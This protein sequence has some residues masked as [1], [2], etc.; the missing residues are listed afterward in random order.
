VTNHTNRLKVSFEYHL[1]L[2]EISA[3]TKKFIFTHFNFLLFTTIPGVFI[4]TFFFRQNGSIATVAIYNAICVFGTALVMQ[5]SSQ[6]S[7]KKSPVFVVR[8]GVLIY[9]VFYV[10]LLLLQKDAVQF[11]PLLAI[12]NAAASGFYWQGYNELMK[13]CTSEDNFDRTVSMMGLANA[14]VTL[15]IPIFSGLLITNLGGK[16]GYSIIFALS[17]LFSL[18]TTYLSTRIEKAKIHGKSNLR[19]V[20]RH[21]LTDRK[22][23]EIYSAEMFRGIRN[24]AFPLFLSIVFFEYI[25]NEAVLGVNS[26]LCGF[27]A[28]FSYIIAAKIVNQGNR[29]K[30]IIIATLCS[31]VV[32]IPLFFIINA[33]ALFLLAIF[34]SVLA[35]YIDNTSIAV[36]YSSFKETRSDINF[37][38]IM[39]AREIFFGAGRVIGYVLLILLS[40]SRFNMA[41]LVLIF[42]I[43]PIITWALFRHAESYPVSTTTVS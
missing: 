22:S 40:G 8:I 34:N 41:L 11:M 1:G 39:A 7:L 35:T 36:F 21:I 42:N 43:T 2:T 29:L 9:N 5:I 19:L 14:V 6:I 4:N 10:S 28:M 20:Y 13:I 3:N 25:S 16:L 24:M 27:A 33:M 31:L 15:A 38:Q 32:A 37:S 18:Y 26:M 12:M 23:F 30:C 17:F